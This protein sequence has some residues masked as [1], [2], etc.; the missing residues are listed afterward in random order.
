MVIA[1]VLPHPPSRTT[2]GGPSP[3]VARVARSLMDPRSIQHFREALITEIA[4]DLQ[5]SW[6]SLLKHVSRSPHCRRLVDA[7]T[8]FSGLWMPMESLGF[9]TR[10]LLAT[11]TPSH[12]AALAT[13]LKRASE[14]WVGAEDEANRVVASHDGSSKPTRWVSLSRLKTHIDSVIRTGR[15]AS[16][17]H[18]APHHEGDGL[19]SSGCSSSV[20][21]D[22]TTLLQTRFR[23]AGDSAYWIPRPQ[24]PPPA[25]VVPL[26]RH[27]PT[28]ENATCVNDDR[29]RTVPV[30]ESHA[31]AIQQ[32]GTVVP[33]PAP[34]R[35][36]C[37]SRPATARPIRNCIT[38]DNLDAADTSR[39]SPLAAAH[40][41]AIPQPLTNWQLPYGTMT[42]IDD[43][44][45]CVDRFHSRRRNI[46]RQALL[47][48]GGGAAASATA[49]A[50]AV[51][52]AAAATPSSSSSTIP[53]TLFIA[54]LTSIPG[55]HVC[56][57]DAEA[58]LDI[59]AGI[60]RRRK[61]L[62]SFMAA[63]A[64]SHQLAAAAVTG[65][66][67]STTAA[68]GS[69]GASQQRSGSAAGLPEKAAG[70]SSEGQH[71]TRRV[72]VDEF[73]DRFGA[74]LLKSKTIRVAVG[75]HQHDGAEGVLE[76]RS[77]EPPPVDTCTSRY[78]ILRPRRSQSATRK[79]TR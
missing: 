43:A 59:M 55:L 69:R 48:P 1:G 72:N 41:H 74:E 18:H 79:A 60:K 10:R 34:P 6:S 70:S 27:Q 42:D 2:P 30:S 53:E 11:S 8:L 67:K 40:H 38:G 9:E 25:S 45:E 4:A 66:N 33:V 52:P 22:D 13:L 12:D 47:S 31:A 56:E 62:P 65:N 23:R 68:G 46:L 29:S 75:M 63:T 26:R 28:A 50:T 54:R 15:A 24:P 73:L 3:M 58:M 78:M 32:Q 5:T 71:V 36:E 19:P 44:R 17:A 39:P 14:F 35:G 77:A 37:R 20:G 61:S 49:S 57:R 16:H 21:I 7:K 51:G 64:R 76:W